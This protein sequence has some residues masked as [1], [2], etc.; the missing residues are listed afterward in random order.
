[1]CLLIEWLQ[2]WSGILQN[3][4]SWDFCHVFSWLGEDYR[5]GSGDRSEISRHD[6][7]SVWAATVDTDLITWLRFFHCKISCAAGLPT[8]LPSWF[9]GSC[10]H[11]ASVYLRCITYLSFLHP[12]KSCRILQENLLIWSSLLTYLIS[13]WIVIFLVLDQFYYFPSLAHQ[14]PPAEATKRLPWWWQFALKWPCCGFEF[15]RLIL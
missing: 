12:H 10:H 9:F 14:L 4:L 7:L 15:Y 1:M 2:H 3:V 5:L 6:L 8:H 11:E 13:Y